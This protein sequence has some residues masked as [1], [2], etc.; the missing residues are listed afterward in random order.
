MT[1]L[2]WVYMG[3]PKLLFVLLLLGATAYFFEVFSRT[4]GPQCNKGQRLM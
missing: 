3:R 2:V 4:A 1:W